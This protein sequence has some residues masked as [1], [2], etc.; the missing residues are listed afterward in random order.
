MIVLSI[1]IIGM[2]SILDRV[3]VPTVTVKGLVDAQLKIVLATNE[4]RLG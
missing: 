1:L 4:K 2:Q 3:N